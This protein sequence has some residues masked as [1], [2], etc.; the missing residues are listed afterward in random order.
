MGNISKENQLIFRQL[1]FHINT[2]TQTVKV[3]HNT[4]SK[5]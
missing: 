5:I 3:T 2:I 4:E 1:F